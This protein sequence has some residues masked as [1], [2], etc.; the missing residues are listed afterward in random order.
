MTIEYENLRKLNQSFSEEF[1]RAFD[2]VMNSG[3]YIL[4]RQV[5]AFEEEFCDYLDYK[6]KFFSVGVASGLDALT[7]SLKSC[8]FSAGGEVIVAANS[9]I[10]S[11]LAIMNAGLVP[12]LVD[13]DPD[14]Y[15]LSPK[16]VRDSI[17]PKTVAVLPV[18]MYGKPCPMTEI[19]RIAAEHRLIVV[20]DCA[21]AHGA[22][23]DGRK[24]GTFGHFGAFS[25]YPTKNLGALGD[26]GAIVVKDESIYMKIRALRNYGSSEKYK[27]DYMGTNSRLDELHAAFLRIKL[28]RLDEIN[29]HKQRLATIYDAN[30][31]GDVVL[32]VRR[33][34]MNDVFHIYPVRHPKRDELKKYLL[35]NDIHTEIHYPIPPHK[36]KAFAS[37]FAGLSFP[38]TEEIHDTILSLPISFIHTEDDV[39]RVVEVINSF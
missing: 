26:G 15:N 4:G 16:G 13:P 1:R 28:R 39:R 5:S 20:E 22:S 11:I 27:N 36:Q 32:P 18:H 10:A 24:V 34:G 37:T 9:Y 19:M 38:V 29:R 8:D 14:T 33:E 21:Q 25:F 30:L 35:A 31:N 3:W 17:S 2:G 12:V 6:N 7:L 23:I